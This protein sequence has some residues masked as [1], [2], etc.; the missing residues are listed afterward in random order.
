M[1]Q[2]LVIVIG[3]VFV[4]DLTAL[5]QF[6]NCLGIVKCEDTALKGARVV[7]YDFVELGVVDYEKDAKITQLRN[8]YNFLHQR[9]LP[10]ALKIYSLDSVV[11][12]RYLLLRGTSSVHLLFKINNK[13]KEIPF[14]STLKKK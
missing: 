13:I 9:L 6:Q 2:A 8:L 12:H 11:Y 1:E 14:K 10:L 7:L 3:E 4:G 5:A